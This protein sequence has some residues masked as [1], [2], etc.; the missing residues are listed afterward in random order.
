MKN[1]LVKILGLCQVNDII[2]MIFNYEN[3]PGC[4]LESAKL[5]NNVNIPSVE[6]MIK[7]AE[8]KGPRKKGYQVKNM[9]QYLLVSSLYN[10]GA[11]CAGTSPMIK[12]F[13]VYFVDEHGRKSGDVFQDL[14]KAY[15]HFRKLVRE[16]FDRDGEKEPL[17][18]ITPDLNK[19]ILRNQL[20]SNRIGL[21]I[22]IEEMQGTYLI[23]D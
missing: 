20:F 16:Y 5:D 19:K 11:G 2:P 18:V 9:K 15:N 4:V 10:G 12:P 14:T 6:N 3:K 17:I 21:D 22:K 8:S 23:A 7:L 13:I 1:N